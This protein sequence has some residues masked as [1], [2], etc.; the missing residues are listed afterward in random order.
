LKLNLLLLLE[1][2]MLLLCQFLLLKVM[3]TLR[4]DNV[5]SR[6]DELL[7]ILKNKSSCPKWCSWKSL[8]G[9]ELVVSAICWISKYWP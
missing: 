4:K 2:K 1:E 3:A 9:P 7:L 5:L 8:V 6:D